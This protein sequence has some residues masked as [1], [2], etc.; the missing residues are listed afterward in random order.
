MD[1]IAKTIAETLRD[2]KKVATISKNLVGLGALFERAAENL[3]ALAREVEKMG[4]AAAETTAE[5]EPQAFSRHEIDYLHS[6]GFRPNPSFVPD[7]SERPNVKVGQ[8]VVW[9][10]MHT[11]EVVGLCDDTSEVCILFPGDGR[12]WVKAS[13]VKPAT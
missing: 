1:D 6:M 4:K 2:P 12:L 9:R 13:D 3:Q 11:G 7:K 10:G 5:P 8:R